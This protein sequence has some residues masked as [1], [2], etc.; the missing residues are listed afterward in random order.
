MYSGGLRV[1]PHIR[2]H[3]AS[4]NGRVELVKTQVESYQM[5][6]DVIAL[7]TQELQARGEETRR[8]K[9]ERLLAFQRDVKERVR[10]K[11]RARLNK[12]PQHQRE[13]K[14]HVAKSSPQPLFLPHAAADT[15]QLAGGS[16]L[17]IDWLWTDAG[18]RQGSC[19]CST[20]CTLIWRGRKHASDE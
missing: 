1:Q 5:G 16:Q 12:L 8:M 7:D 19:T 11:E 15:D 3:I 2:G 13:E 10:R 14:S 20:D 9:E 6:G 17:L 4:C 18:A